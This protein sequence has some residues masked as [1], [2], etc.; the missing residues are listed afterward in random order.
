MSF[1]PEYVISPGDMLDVELVHPDGTRAL[2]LG[3]IDAVPETMTGHKA[4]KMRLVVTAIHLLTPAEPVALGPLRLVP[5][6]D[7]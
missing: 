1:R 4:I 2:V 3:R 5:S 7:T 6:S